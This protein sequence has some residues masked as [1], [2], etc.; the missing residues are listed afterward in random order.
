MARATSAKLPVDAAC[1]VAF[2]ADDVKATDVRNSLAE[3]DVGAAAGHV[4]GDGD[5]AVL[6]GASNDLGFLLMVLR[7]QNVVRDAGALEHPGEHFTGVDA[8]G[9][10]E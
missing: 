1:F 4:R 9:A 7:V 5:G 6:A 8:H 3:F 10:D 2:A